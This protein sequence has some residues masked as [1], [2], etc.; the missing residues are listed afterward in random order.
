MF[1]DTTILTDT[2]FSIGKDNDKALWYLLDLLAVAKYFRHPKVRTAFQSQS[3]RLG[4]RWGLIGEA[5][6]CEKPTFN[7]GNKVNLNTAWSKYINKEWNDATK[8]AKDLMTKELGQM[9]KELKCDEVHDRIAKAGKGNILPKDAQLQEQCVVLNFIQKEW[10]G[11][12]DALDDAPLPEDSE[13]ENEESD[14]D[15]GPKQLAGQTRPPP[16]TPGNSETGRHDGKKQKPNGKRQQGFS[17]F[18]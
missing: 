2:R 17:F 15:E 4:A 11:N 8:R 7:T 6:T 10:K 13:E 1:A 18:S 5:L 3:R 12:S 16:T 9:E 14:E